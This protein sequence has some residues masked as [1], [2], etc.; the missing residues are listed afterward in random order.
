[1]EVHVTDRGLQCVY[2]TDNR[3][4]PGILQQSPEIDYSNP[5]ADE[6]NTSYVVLGRRDAPVQ[7]TID[8]VGELVE[9][10]QTWLEYGRFKATHGRVV[11]VDAASADGQS[12]NLRDRTSADGRDVGILPIDHIVR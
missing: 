6:P 2:F 12:R 4:N 5:T 7:L 1:M 3:G 8:Q 10:L 9:Y 11:R